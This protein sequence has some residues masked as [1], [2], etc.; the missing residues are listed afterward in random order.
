MGS[1]SG[2]ESKADYQARMLRWVLGR[3]NKGSSTSIDL[4]KMDQYKAEADKALRSNYFGVKDEAMNLFSNVEK[5][6]LD[7]DTASFDN[8]ELGDINLANLESGVSK[9][10]QNDF[11]AQMQT[12][13]EQRKKAILDRT[14][15]PG[16]A[17]TR[18][19]ML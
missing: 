7:A 2:N 1:E 3:T 10:A 13:F 6:A 12:I 9:T 15:R 11:L 16:Q 8:M 14:L 19:E 17:A 18:G 5:I 4:G